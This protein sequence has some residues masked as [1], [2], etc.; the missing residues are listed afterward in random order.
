MLPE[1]LVPEPS[2][3]LQVD[4]LRLSCLSSATSTPELTEY[5][6]LLADAPQPTSE[7]LEYAAR[8]KL[9]LFFF[10]EFFQFFTL[11]PKLSFP[12]SQ[13]ASQR[14]AR[15]LFAANG[16]DFLALPDAPAR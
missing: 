1:Y 13:P 10:S 14:V 11:K 16:L 6:A 8:T 15:S 4:L 2:Q 5:T 7:R 9:P 3:P 12:L